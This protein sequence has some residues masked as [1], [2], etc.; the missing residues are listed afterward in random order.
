M[1]KV[2]TVVG[3]ELQS[4]TGTSHE[5]IY[6]GSKSLSDGAHSDSLALYSIIHSPYS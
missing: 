3:H 4:T 2:V 6:F 5:A 1:R